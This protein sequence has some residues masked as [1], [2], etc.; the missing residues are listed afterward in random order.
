MG[1]LN[2]A[3]SHPEVVIQSVAARDRKKAEEFAK[4]HGI[5]DVK[6]TYEG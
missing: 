1:L 3:K 6:D 2:P 4:T 5:P